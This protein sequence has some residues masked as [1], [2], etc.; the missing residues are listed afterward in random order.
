LSRKR[1]YD[2]GVFRIVD[3]N[4]E[5]VGDTYAVRVRL[6]ENSPWRLRYGLAFTDKLRVD[7]REL[8]LSTDLTYSNVFGR[9]VTTGTSFRFDATGREVRLFSGLPT[10]IGHDVR[11]N[12]SFFGKR[13][14]SDDFFISDEVGFAVQ[15]QWQMRNAFILSYDYNYRRNRT[16]ERD[17]DPDNP[18]AFDLRIPIARFNASVTRDTRDDILNASRGMF[19]SNSFELAPPGVGSAIRF[20]KN[21]VQFFSF[22]PLKEGITWAQAFRVG[23]GRAF[24]EQQLINSEQFAAG[25]STTVRGF[26]QNELTTDRGNAALILN[27][28]LRF[29]LA[30]W[31]SGAGFVDVGNIYPAASDFNPFKLRYA[32]GVG[33]RV[34][35]PLILI[36]FDV[37]FNP[38]KRPGEEPNRFSFGIG[39]AF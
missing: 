36:R 23:L 24:G 15:Q 3:L 12:F 19:L 35:T 13:D 14:L 18:F 34:Q 33:L 1:L 2:T 10:L 39:Q 32:P 38:S 21:Y 29:P 20:V 16:Y 28:E 31:F 4:I 8:G 11:T 6:V 22:R 37:G 17:L 30:W 27:Q 9:G 7:R 5:P 26:K 25:G